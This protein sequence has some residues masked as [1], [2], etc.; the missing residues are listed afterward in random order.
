MSNASTGEKQ[1]AARWAKCPNCDGWVHVSDALLSLGTVDLHCPACEH[2]FPPR[3]AA[4][5]V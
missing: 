5:T 2:D 4:E 3:D 1:G